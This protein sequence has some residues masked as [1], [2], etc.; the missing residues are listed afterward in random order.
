MFLLLFVGIAQAGKMAEGFR[1]L[2]WGE[3][4]PF[5]APGDRCV[6]Y[7][8]EAVI[9]RCEQ[10]IGDVPVEIAYVYEHKMLTGVLIYSD[11]FTNCTA[12]IDVMTA[13]YG[14]STP[15]S[16]YATGRMDDRHWRD[17]GVFGSWE[18]NKYSGKC[19]AGII[20]I[21]SLTRVDEI[22]KKKAVKGV[23]DL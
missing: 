15:T 20:H 12:L 5:A 6:S 11:G 18:W 2:P 16:K 8:E 3:Q 23:D 9:W 19:Q 13:A 21:E 10:T 17:T 14:E 7:P 1:G 22:K 4:E